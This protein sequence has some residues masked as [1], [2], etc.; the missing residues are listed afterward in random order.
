MSDKILVM[1]EGRPEQ[2]G[3][4]R[5]VYDEPD[6]EFVAD[7]MGESNI[8]DATVVE[9]GA[10]GLE[11]EV[12]DG[13]PITVSEQA[14]VDGAPTTDQVALSLRAEDLQ[15]ATDP[16][17]NG[18]SIPGTVKTRTFRGK[19]TSYLVDI[20]D[21]EIVVETPGKR[22]EEAI[23]SGDEVAVTWEDGECLLLER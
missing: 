1:N 20:G 3:A 13:V 15:L 2:I 4:P 9:Q 18:S 11:L 8:V 16:G 10:S 22:A 5:S 19:V 17:R 6:N 12:E 21:E 7:F 14:L 23:E